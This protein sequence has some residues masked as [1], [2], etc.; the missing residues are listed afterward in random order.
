MSLETY[1]GYFGNVLCG[2]YPT[3]VTLFFRQIQKLARTRA[4]NYEG[5]T[6]AP[7]LI[8]KYDPYFTPVLDASC[9]ELL[10]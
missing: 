1:F 2:S 7:R 4:Q 3:P 9:L 10:S 5:L 8:T 6:R